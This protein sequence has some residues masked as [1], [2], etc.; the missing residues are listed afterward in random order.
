MVK[1]RKPATENKEGVRNESINYSWGI[2][3][4]R[5]ETRLSYIQRIAGSIEPSVWSVI[6]KKRGLRDR[7]YDREMHVNKLH[8]TLNI[9]M[10]Y[11]SKPSLLSDPQQGI[12]Y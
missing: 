9:L 8:I 10:D 6:L 3:A 12:K 11:I 5:R 2:I 4:I 1:V 7:I